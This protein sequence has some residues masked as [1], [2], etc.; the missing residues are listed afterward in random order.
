MT[1]RSFWFLLNG[2][3]E[4]ANGSARF[5]LGFHQHGLS[6]TGYPVSTPAPVKNR[7]AGGV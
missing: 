5:W 7:L 6:T 2:Q 4:R 3:E 1:Q